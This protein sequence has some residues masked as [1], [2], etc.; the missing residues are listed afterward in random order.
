M[1]FYTL[2]RYI[3]DYSMDGNFS[4]QK[5]AE[6]EFTAHVQ[7]LPPDL[8]ELAL[9]EGTDDGLIVEA[10]WIHALS[11]LLDRKSVV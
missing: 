3:Q 2:A 7:T 8:R 9:L 10:H 1:R 11:E 5:A 6:K 4:G